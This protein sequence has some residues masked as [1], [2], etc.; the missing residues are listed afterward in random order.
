MGITTEKI[1]VF[2]SLLS[3]AFFLFLLMVKLPYLNDESYYL[4]LKRID[5]IILTNPLENSISFF[6]LD[7]LAAFVLE[8]EEFYF[9]L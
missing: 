2:A 6:E 9:P 7:L 1:I 3:E 4:A 5:D 8:F